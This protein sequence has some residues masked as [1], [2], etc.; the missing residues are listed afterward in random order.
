VDDHQCAP[1]ARSDGA[2]PVTR[3]EK[4]IDSAPIRSPGAKRVIDSVP[5]RSP[6]A[7]R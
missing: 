7:K 2:D 3:R 1:D 4:V 5:I 6:G